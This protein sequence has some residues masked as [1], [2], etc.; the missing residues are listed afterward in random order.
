MEPKRELLEASSPSSQ[1]GC[2]KEAE[3]WLDTLY[4]KESE[5]PLPGPS[6]ESLKGCLQALLQLSKA[7]AGV[8]AEQTFCLGRS[9]LP[10]YHQCWA[11]QKQMPGQEATMR[12]KVATVDA[13]KK[14][15]TTKKK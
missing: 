14:K 7:I 4:P 3:P 12:K 9:A 15:K 10:C 5:R 13:P 6:R 1:K 8:F 2:T 11:L